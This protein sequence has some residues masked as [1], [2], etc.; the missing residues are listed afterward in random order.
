MKNFK[1]LK[2]SFLSAAGVVLYIFLVAGLII[3]GNE[4]FG[5]PD[6]YFGPVI[7]LL[8]FVFSALIT[9]LLVLARPV[10]LY[11]E[12]ERIAAIRLLLFT[13]GWL[14]VIM[15]VVMAVRLIIYRA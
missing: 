12:K 1:I 3:H 10:M 2:E 7:F 13:T 11:L 14:L 8:L 9:G 5:R 6:N 15:V 4:L